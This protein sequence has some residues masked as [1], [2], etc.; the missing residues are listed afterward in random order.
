MIWS[1]KWGDKIDWLEGLAQEGTILKPYREKPVLK[2]YLAFYWQAFNE[3]VK[4]NGINFTD[5]KAYIE[6]F[7]IKDKDFFVTVIK[8]LEFEWVRLKNV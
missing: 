3:L 8:A 6:L 2:P 7:N 4:E 1:S 5:M